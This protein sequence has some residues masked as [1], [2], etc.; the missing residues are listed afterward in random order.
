MAAELV[1]AGPGK[2]VS[3]TASHDLESLFYVL[4]GI[5]I[6]FNEPYI[7]KPE[8]ELTQCF[9]MYFNTSEPSLMKTITI[10]SQVGWSFKIL[11]HISP[12]FQPLIPL[13]NTLR[14]RIILPIAFEDDSFQTDNPITHDEMKELLVKALCELDDEHWVCRTSSHL[15]RNPLLPDTGATSQ[16]NAE[17]PSDTLNQCASDS[18][19]ELGAIQYT[20]GRTAPRMLR[21]TSYRE[22]SG[23]GFASSN[24]SGGT[25]RQLSDDE[26][27]DSD[28]RATKRARPAPPRRFIGGSDEMPAAT[29]PVTRRFAAT[30]PLLGNPN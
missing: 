3:H 5:C 10:Q 21:P 13:L 19:P 18:T 24:S 4:L 28:P 1:M 14:N 15:N 9:D 12:Y 25:R 29:G 16:I 23:P 20:A 22:V 6:F 17:S 27:V 30:A 11:R 26:Y 7:Q 8:S 2:P